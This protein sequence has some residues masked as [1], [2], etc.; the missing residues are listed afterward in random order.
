MTKIKSKKIFGKL[1]GYYGNVEADLSYSGIFE[2]AIAVVLSAQTTDKQVNSVTPVL[3]K[4]FPGFA[5]LSGAN[6]QE[7]KTIIKSVGLYKTKAKNI[8][9]LS[10]EVVKKYNNT[11][12]DEFEELI[13][14][15]GIG[16]KSANVILAMGYGKAAFPVDTH[17]I[18]I[19]NRLGFIKT[20]DPYK[21]E[22][23]LTQYIEQKD[24][25]QAHLLLIR[26]GRKICNAK[27]PLCPEC[28]VRDLCDFLKT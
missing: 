2:L 28:P 8:I 25:K 13:T 17:I 7:V 23:I 19:A 3:F 9:N 11:L 10:K 27:K 18:R 21:V 4:K 20:V 5:E 15:P 26:H 14:L 12:P 24:W 6:L 1:K 16:R 22:M